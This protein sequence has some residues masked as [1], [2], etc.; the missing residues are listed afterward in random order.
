M[1]L[2]GSQTI[3]PLDSEERAAARRVAERLRVE[4]E[5]LV[6]SLPEHL[7]GGAAM[8]REL[9]VDRSTCQRVAQ[10]VRHSGN[11]LEVL[12]RAPGIEG[13]RLITLALAKR[14]TASTLIVRA[15][16]ALNAFARLIE[17][18]AGSQAALVRRVQAVG[19]G[20][21]DELGQAGEAALREQAFDAMALLTR[22]QLEVQSNVIVMRPLPED[23]GRVQ[24]V[25]ARQMIGLSGR[26]GAP[27][28]SGIFFSRANEELPDGQPRPLPLEGVAEA[29]AELAEGSTLLPRFCSQPLPT[30]STRL[31]G[32]VTL[33]LIE[34]PGGG[35]PPI[36][37]GLAYRLE[38]AILHPALQSN[39]R[40]EIYY[41]CLVPTRHVRLFAYMHRS[42]AG[43]CIADAF[44]HQRSIEVLGDSPDPWFDRLDQRL[45]VEI[46]GSELATAVDETTPRQ[47]EF[48]ATLF[49]AVGW[50]PADF[51]GF[52]LALE[53]P[54]WG[55]RTTM[56]FEFT[57][58]QPI[59]RPVRE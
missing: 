44:V 1:T 5:Q 52:R 32:D 47:E 18:L 33:E 7:R 56:A 50:S 19:A 23:P 48:L 53:H 37:V 51:V 45:L 57:D 6:L 46:L 39:R 41:H 12:V 29:G 28:V 43:R 21:Q 14:G 22:R 59:P 15:N 13:L 42:M 38:P 17:K 49:E 27:P 34:P 58:L 24:L 20:G 11:P 55:T 8:S 10:A 4:L 2:P 54:I 35:A 3:R 36:D 26:S 16:E 40:L 9:G 25:G 31:V 30:V